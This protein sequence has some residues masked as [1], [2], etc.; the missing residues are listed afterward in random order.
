MRQVVASSQDGWHVHR[1]RTDPAPSMGAAVVS[2]GTPPASDPP[3]MNTRLGISGA[4]SQIYR[5][6]AAHQDLESVLS[7]AEQVADST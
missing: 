7:P 5:L 6:S 4:G 2:N 1:R 3:G